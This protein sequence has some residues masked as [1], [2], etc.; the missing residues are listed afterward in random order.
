MPRV[1]LT[2]SIISRSQRTGGFHQSIKSSR[3]AHMTT[4]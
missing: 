1:H 2:S 4:S 3:I